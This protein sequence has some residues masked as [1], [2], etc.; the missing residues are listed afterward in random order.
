[1]LAYRW[2]WM[3]KPGGMEEVLELLRAEA[4]EF[5]PGYAK[6]RVYTPDISPQ[7]LVYELT[8][9]NQE[10][11]DKFFD[12]FNATPGAAAFWEK[13]NEL[14]KRLVVT[15]RWNVMELG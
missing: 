11:C 8:V 15:E 10:A 7:M 12:E 13:W 4:K 14:T 2:T 5:N 6:A 3:V 1:M 9:E